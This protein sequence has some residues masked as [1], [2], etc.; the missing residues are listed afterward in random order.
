MRNGLNHS[1]LQWC[2]ALA[3][4]GL[5]IVLLC[6]VTPQGV[7]AEDGTGDWRPTYDL[8]MRWI[9]FAVLVFLILR[10]ARKPLVNF[11]REK[12][13]D[14][15]KEIQ[16]V[17]KEKAEILAKVEEIL[18]ARD[19]GQEKLEKLQA[20]ILAQGKAKKERIIEGARKESKLML[21]SARRKIE[22]QMKAAHADIRA[23]MID[24]AIDMALRKLPDVI[25]AKDNQ[26][27]YDQYLEN[28][29]TPS[30]L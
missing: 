17:E 20:R 14:V 3:A 9:N 16:V 6:L 26:K 2:R 22:S 1:M 5:V 13:E 12:S 25:D 28:T 23:E 29:E 10:Y 11:F 21:E 7:L 15:K 24:H 19:Q 30:A 27:L 4:A 18:K 8:V